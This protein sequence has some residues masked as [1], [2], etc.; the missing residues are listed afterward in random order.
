MTGKRALPMHLRN[1]PSTHTRECLRLCSYGYGQD[2]AG[3]EPHVLTLA[4][5]KQFARATVGD[6][7]FVKIAIRVSLVS[8]AVYI[9][10]ANSH[11]KGMLFRNSSLRLIKK[12][13]RE[14]DSTNY[15]IFV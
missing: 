1:H 4:L 9:T 10:C 7:Q 2:E 13:S 5:R 3:P 8:G 15:E 6:C 11:I 12:I 14:G